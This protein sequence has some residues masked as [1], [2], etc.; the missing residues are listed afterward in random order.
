MN[1]KMDP[2]DSSLLPI[3]KSGQSKSLQRL[4]LKTSYRNLEAKL[5]KKEK[6]LN[7]SV[8][9]H[10]NLKKSKFDT[11]EKN[12]SPKPHREL[13]KTPVLE[14]SILIDCNN[15]TPFPSKISLIPKKQICKLIKKGQPK[16]N[17][18]INPMLFKPI[19]NNR[20]Q[21][22]DITKI[23]HIPDPQFITEIKNPQIADPVVFQ[24]ELL[25]PPIEPITSTINKNI[26]HMKTP[27]PLIKTDDSKMFFYNKFTQPS[28][29]DE[30][31]IQEQEEEP[32]FLSERISYECE[33]NQS[34]GINIEKNEKTDSDIEKHDDTEYLESLQ[35]SLYQ[36]I[37]KNDNGTQTEEKELLSILK[38]LD[39]GDIKLGIKF[40]SQLSQ[41]MKTFK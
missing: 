32:I 26:H 28:F 25:V 3:R 33:S 23:A 30:E 7:K 14:D 41:F 1:H 5:K 10:K 16:T 18:H 35:N 12:H 24:V 21:E 27:I 4:N 29:G 19:L 9:S 39:H 40:I 20:K 6:N 34:L 38:C 8:K 22:K 2:E 17:I 37:E 15:Q 13:I 11:P 31:L 36:D